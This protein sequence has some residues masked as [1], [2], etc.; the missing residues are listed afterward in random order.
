MK[1]HGGPYD[2]WFLRRGSKAE[3][4]R[5]ERRSTGGLYTLTGL[6]PAYLAR[7]LTR[8]ARQSVRLCHKLG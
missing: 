2:W 8:K 3:E 4:E 6:S 7:N 5:K 1:I